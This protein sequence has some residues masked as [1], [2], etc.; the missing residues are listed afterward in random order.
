MHAQRLIF[1]TAL[2]TTWR[3]FVPT[4]GGTF[5]GIGL[6]SLCGI[7]PIATVVCLAAG[8]LVSVLLIARQLHTVRK[9]T[10]S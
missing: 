3:A 9:S 2:D 5:I 7:A 1:L 10:R 8:G 4:V 6:D